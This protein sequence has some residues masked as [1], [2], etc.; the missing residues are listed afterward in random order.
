MVNKALQFLLPD[1]ARP[2]AG[3]ALVREQR[4]L[5]NADTI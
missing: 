1:W 5:R 4:D 3:N 2:V